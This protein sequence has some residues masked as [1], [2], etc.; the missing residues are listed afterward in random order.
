MGRYNTAKN[1]TA[2]S[3][4]LLTVGNGNSLAKSNALVVLKNAKI[5]VNISNFE[6]T[7]ADAQL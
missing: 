5:G 4:R 7:K 3:E 6:T 2:T 1:S